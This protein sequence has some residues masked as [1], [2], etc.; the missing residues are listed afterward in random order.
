MIERD[1]YPLKKAAE[2]LN[3]SEQEIIHFAAKGAISIAVIIGN[4]ILLKQVIDPKTT[5]TF[6]GIVGE[7]GEGVP[8][9]KV[10]KY[11]LR[12]YE[13]GVED[14]EVILAI[15]FPRRS[16][17]NT[18]VLKVL[19]RNTGR[20]LLIKNS[21]LVILP[22]DFNNLQQQTNFTTSIVKKSAY[23]D[24]DNDFKLWIETENS[25]LDTMTKAEIHSQ[26]KLRNPQLWTMG[27]LDWWKQQELYKGKPG[28]PPA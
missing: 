15:Y 23:E 19:D 6:K 21:K 5:R 11:C 7:L 22:D 13:A 9:I 20:P 16:N 26:L 17:A 10:D 4:G 27:F 24:R 12:D 25:D 14:V 8:P 18:E 28:R 1:F 3:Y 2:L